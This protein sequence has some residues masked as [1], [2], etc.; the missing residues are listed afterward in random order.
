MI[1]PGVFGALSGELDAF[2]GAVGLPNKSYDW[3]CCG[4]SPNDGRDGVV[5]SARLCTGVRSR[6]GVGVCFGV[7]S[8]LGV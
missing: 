6:F 3:L 1:S 7:R 2:E 5:G 8:C 4:D